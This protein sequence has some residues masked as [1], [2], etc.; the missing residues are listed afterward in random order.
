MVVFADS[1]VFPPRPQ[2]GLGNLLKRHR[3]T[4][5]QSPPGRLML[6]RSGIEYWLLVVMRMLVA[7]VDNGVVSGVP[8]WMVPAAATPKPTPMSGL[9]VI[10]GA[11]DVCLRLGVAGGGEGCH[12]PVS[13]PSH[14][15]K[16]SSGAYI[17]PARP[18]SVS[19]PE[20]APGFP[21]PP[22]RAPPAVS[23]TPNS[24]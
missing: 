4:R 14:C 20:R 11:I 21:A 2:V 12:H 8:S 16:S 5:F 13:R 10:K 6:V 18:G 19:G 9:L 22:A 15:G 23:G 3:P 24:G 7:N 1:C 17:W